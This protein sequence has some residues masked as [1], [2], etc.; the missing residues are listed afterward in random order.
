MTSVID[1][2]Q[3]NLVVLNGDLTS[4][5]FV[6]PENLTSLIDQITAP[7]TDRNMPYAATFGN[8]DMSKTCSTRIMSEHMRDN[9]KGKDGKRLS[10]T[11][12]FVPGPYEKV[13]T[14][15]YYIPVYA[16]SGGGNP[17]LSLMLY[18]FDS[19]GGRD[20]QKT[21]SNG[22]DVSVPGWVDDKV[23]LEPSRLPRSVM[24]HSPSP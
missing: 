16:S 3:P 7:L 11:T 22:N 23:S 1:S 18:F 5:E 12:S 17:R 21:D 20:Y 8:H 10:F 9:E 15:N 19:R 24:M 4:C 13:G 6:A 14:S 2:E